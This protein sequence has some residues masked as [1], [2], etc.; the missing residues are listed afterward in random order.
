MLFKPVILSK[1]DDHGVER[2]LKERSTYE[3]AEQSIVKTLEKEPPG[4]IG[5]IHVFYVAVDESAL[6]TPPKPSGLIL[7]Q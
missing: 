6:I 1:Q 7:P 4:S 3:L 2:D 5:Q